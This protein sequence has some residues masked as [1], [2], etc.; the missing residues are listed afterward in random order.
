MKLHSGLKIFYTKITNFDKTMSSF[1][2]KQKRW[3]QSISGVKNVGKDTLFV[4]IE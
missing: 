2:F 1:H 4:K 3:L